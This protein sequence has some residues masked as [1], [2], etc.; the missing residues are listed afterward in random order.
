MKRVEVKWVDSCSPERYWNYEVDGKPD[1]IVTVGFLVKKHKKTLVICASS[2]SGGS[3]GGWMTIPR[4]A[5]K[6]V[7]KLK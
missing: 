4:V 6:S 2:G 5:V 1:H 3:K 7:R